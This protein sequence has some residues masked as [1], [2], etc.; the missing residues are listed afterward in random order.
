MGGYEHKCAQKRR[1]REN[2]ENERDRAMERRRREGQ[3][4]SG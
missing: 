2:G 1:E 3:I 4:H